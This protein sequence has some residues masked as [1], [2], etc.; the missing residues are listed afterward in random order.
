VS[1]GLFGNFFWPGQIDQV[2]GQKTHLGPPGPTWWLTGHLDQ[3]PPGRSRPFGSPGGFWA[4][5]W[6]WQLKVEPLSGQVESLR[7]PRLY[8]QK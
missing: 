8:S 6:S 1:K 2:G 3:Y 5:G 4:G 7:Q